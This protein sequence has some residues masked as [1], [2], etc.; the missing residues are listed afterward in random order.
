MVLAAAALTTG[1]IAIAD[2]QHG[3]NRVGRETAPLAQAAS[4]LY[5][6]LSDLDSQTARQILTTG[7]SAL[8]TV[9]GDAQ[10]TV[11]SRVAE[12]DADLR[13]AI[14]GTSDPAVQGQFQTMLD[15][16]TLYHDLSATAL[17]LDQLSKDATKGHPD[18]VALAYYSRATDVMHFNL[19]PTAAQIRDS[20]AHQLTDSAKSENDSWSVDTLLVVITTV[21]LLAALILFQVALSRRFHRTLN[22]FLALATVATAAFLVSGLSMTAQQS[23]R[24][25]QVVDQH[26]NP[27]L[28]IQHARAVSYDAVG[29]I[30]RYAVAPDF[31]YDHGYAADIAS[32]NGTPATPGLL[33]AGLNGTGQALSQRAGTDWTSVQRDAGKIKS[34]VDGGDVDSALTEATGIA[35]GQLGQDFY[36]LDTHL[37]QAAATQLAAFQATMADAQSGASGW[38]AVPA[39]LFGAVMALTLVGVWRR[40]AEYR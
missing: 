31:G 32:L 23:D 16:V 12:I 34:E 15:K 14:G 1:T 21:L 22:P 37:G 13:Q 3:V 30:V 36:A 5:F 26:M 11:N 19:L 27:Y 18:S 10:A 24:L 9:Q 17:T 8:D 40:L 2:T 39:V 25:K 7:D 33:S 35:G 38:G 28:G 20:Y 29:S 6:A 4:D